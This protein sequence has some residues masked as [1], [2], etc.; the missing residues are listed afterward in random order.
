MGRNI[1]V[2]ADWDGLARPVPL[3]QLYA[4]E[5][6]GTEVFSFECAPGVATQ[7]QLQG[8]YLDPRLGLFAGRQFP[9]AGSVNFGAFLDN[10][11][12]RWGRTLMQRSHERAKR[13]G[14]IPSSQHLLESDY[15]LGVHDAYRPGALRFKVDAAGPFL[16]ARDYAA[17]P[18]VQLQE[19][20]KASRA[21]E[22]TDAN[23][24]DIDQWLRMLIAPGGSLG[25]ARPKVN[26]VDDDGGIW[27]AKFPSINDQYDIGAWELVVHALAQGCGITVSPANV[28]RYASAHRTFLVKR[29]DRT[30]AGRRLQYASAM[31]LTGHRDGD[32]AA[33]GA[34]Y[35]EIAQVLMKHGAQ[36]SA[37]LE[38]L[39][40]RIVFNMCVSNTD[41]HLRNHGFLLE[42]RK[43]WRLSPAFDMNP[44]PHGSALRLNVNTAENAL[45][46]DLAVS[47]AM[48]FRIK[49]NRAEELIARIKRVVSQWR[50]LAQRLQIPAAECDR[51]AAAFTRAS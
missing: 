19:L 17:A 2:Y 51:M 3:G 35:L 41:D 24:P 25:G 4:Q 27:I 37:D 14:E 47:V 16:D 33:S 21:I 6:G 40:M 26:V 12:D 28:R 30:A 5:A 10:A 44:V 18:M 22:S 13:R 38:Q 1:A 20:E 8:L 9:T 48:L 32:D 7:A 31:T 36:P 50:T 34:S 29:F 11:P 43:G 15:L 23:A 42:P 49:P 39:W 46:L 45:D